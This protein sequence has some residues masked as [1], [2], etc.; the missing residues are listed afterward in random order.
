MKRQGILGL[1]RR[2]GMSTIRIFNQWHPTPVIN[3]S[4]ELYLPL[5]RFIH[6]PIAVFC[7]PA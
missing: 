2:G 5:G 7:A 3:K 4:Y 1:D 6:F